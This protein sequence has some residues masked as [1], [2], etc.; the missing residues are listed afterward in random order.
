MTTLAEIK[1][2]METALNAAGY[3]VAEGKA[4]LWDVGG[5]DL[6]VPAFGNCFGNNPAAPYIVPIVP[7]REGEV[8]DYGASMQWGRNAQGDPLY[9]T[10]RLREDEAILMFG[11][12]PPEGAYLG[13]ET[14]LFTRYFDVDNITSP[15]MD[16]LND[17]IGLQ[18]Q[19]SPNPDNILY[20]KAPKAVGN[21]YIKD[22]DRVLLFANIGPTINRRVLERKI[23][24]DFWEQQAIFS[25]SPD[26]NF[27]AMLN[28]ALQAIDPALVGIHAHNAL[29]ADLKMGLTNHDDDFWTLMR[30]A[31]PKVKEEG[32][33]WRKSLADHL[34]V[35]RVS[36]RAPNVVI[37]H[38][39]QEF[40]EKTYTTDERAL[41]TGL[42]KVANAV[43]ANL[44]FGLSPQEV[45]MTTGNIPLHGPFTIPRAMNNLGATHDTDTYRLSTARNFGSK[46]VFAIVGVNHTKTKNASY[47]SIGVYDSAVL[48]GLHGISQG[49]GFDGPLDGSVEEFFEITGAPEN[50]SGIDLSNF[51]VH[52]LV[53]PDSDI[54]DG[55]KDTPLCSV[56]KAMPDKSAKGGAVIP[57]DTRIRVSQR[58][59]LNPDPAAS[60][61]ADHTR[62][63]SPILLVKGKG[64]KTDKMKPEI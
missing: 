11:N 12:M 59:Y 40:E 37:R 18:H 64:T 50:I 14:F 46:E 47:V 9:A 25:I 39:R 42:Q 20:N 28:S 52:I 35:F 56:I 7:H 41:A 1:V 36:K 19:L 53:R 4:H 13:Y 33:A 32:D 24:N 2:K 62:T 23:G 22:Q 6:V 3:D 38:R 15:H 27:E 31:V 54:P 8:Y 60:C 21:K 30:Y 44:G 34:M 45:L 48:T 10:Y 49:A 55:L 63:L 57:I 43:S 26:A 16:W 17:A 5:C 29:G 51:Y 58:G 61:G